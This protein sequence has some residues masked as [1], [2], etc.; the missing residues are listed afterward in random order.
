MATI[1]HLIKGEG[2]PTMAP[3]AVGAHYIDTTGRKTYIA[4]GRESAA[5]WGEPLA[6]GTTSGGGGGGGVLL[7]ISSDGVR[8]YAGEPMAQASFNRIPEEAILEVPD[9]CAFDL[10]LG[11]VNMAPD[12]RHLLIR[13]LGIVLSDGWVAGE[14]TLVTHSFADGA[15]R[16]EAWNGEAMYRV[17]VS[18]QFLSLYP[19]GEWPF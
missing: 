3:P 1:E 16:L 11:G 6:T 2:A 8:Q 19:L 17:V 5:D 10:L 14:S 15:L 12:G 7:E 13:G 4:T 18:G 9:T